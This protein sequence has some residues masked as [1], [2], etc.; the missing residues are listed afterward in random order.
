MQA[1]A[2]QAATRL[3]EGKVKIVVVDPVM[4]GGAINPMLKNGKW[5]PILPAT[6]GAFGMGLIQWIIDNKRYDE[7]YLSSPNLDAAKKKGYNSWSNASH[8]VIVDSKHPNKLKMLR[9][10]DL[11][12]NVSEDEKHPFISIDKASGE[13]KLIK[14]I[15]DADLHFDG[16]VEGKDKKSIKVKTAFLMLKESADRY[17]LDEYSKA[18]GIDKSVIIDIAKEYTSYGTKASTDGLGG[19]AT[20]NGLDLTF[21]INTL[22]TLVGSTN[23]K[24]GIIPRRISY[25]TFSDG[26]RYKLKQIEG[27]PS[28]KALPISRT[29]VKYED[30]DE[31]K[32]KVARG[33]NPYP[34]KL[35]WHPI[36]SNSDNQMMFSMIH[37]YPYSAKIFVNWMANPLL[38]LPGA[39][40]TE[41]REALKNPEIVPLFIS[42]DAYM[43]ETTALADYIVPD[44]TPYE[45]WGLANIE[46]N[47]S[48]KGTTV[49]WPVVKPGTI[50]LEDGRHSSYETFLIDVAKAIGMPGFGKGAITDMN[51]K[52]FDLNDAHNFFLK[53]IANMAYDDTQVK[54]ISQEEIDLQDLEGALEKY[55]DSLSSEEEW[56]KIMTIISRGGRFEEHG[57]GFDGDN[58]IYTTDAC[59]SVYSE[60]LATSRN[61]FNGQQFEYG[62]SSW[63]PQRFMDG[64]LVSEVFSNDEWPFKAANHKAKFRSISMLSNTKLKEI[65]LSNKVQMNTED[66]RAL[67]IKTG[68]NV[69]VI[70][71]T[72]GEF[73]GQALVR[74]GIAK[75]TIGVAYGYGH[76]E[77]GA[78]SFAIDGKE[79]K[80]DKNIGEGFHLMNLLDPSIKDTFAF[81]EASTGGP[82]RSG[83]AYRL[84]KL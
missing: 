68:D 75:G 26:P 55:K 17:T 6:D 29:G 48:G 22:S 11:G 72:G 24:G 57:A 66:A 49:R 32:Q 12:I 53:G 74:P 44:T 19:T 64:K 63:N 10:E 80:A 79:H 25:K 69:R 38:A 3:T 56:K 45:S 4:V 31:Y 33:E 7:K 43:A 41:V 8:L 71:A 13:P 50:E 59:F 65:N 35:P 67:G 52:K 30:T 61:S 37:Q 82:S 34:S 39:A 76:W 60:R 70:P 78:K 84:E 54:G 58:R 40:R 16:T 51:G 28:V 27:K 21:I 9:A 23:K 62:T 77:Y 5:V 18:C 83:G 20:A 14:D 42:I 46:G 73:E 2:R 47:F 36:G 1:M 15:N 81:S